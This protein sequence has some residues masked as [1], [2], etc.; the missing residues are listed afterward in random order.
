MRDDTNTGGDRAVSAA[1]VLQESS[2]ETF[3]EVWNR[4]DL[5]EGWRA[6]IIEE[7]IVTSPPPGS[8][9]NL[10]ADSVTRS[11]YA[12]IPRELV[13][14]QTVG[15]FLPRSGG[16]CVPDL[17]VIEREQVGDGSSGISA[18]DA[19]LAAEI[20]SKSNA[21][22]DRDAKHRAYAQA[23]IPL[24]LLIDRFAPRWPTVTLFSEPDGDA[25]RES[26]AVPFG[27]PIE[28]PSP[29]DVTL[30]TEEFPR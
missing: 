7:R 9:H 23:G 22:T 25:Y 6:E 16:L 21:D 24:Y 4:L 8:N 12:V 1:P 27:K 18:E 17:V 15:M 20:T 5:P 10:I 28:L 2:W 13:I 26:H 19:L 11:C 30:E 3:V 14:F 29:F